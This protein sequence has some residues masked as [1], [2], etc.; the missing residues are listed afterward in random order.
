MSEP[1]QP[2]KPDQKQPQ[3]APVAIPHTH[4]AGAGGEGVHPPHPGQEVRG[5]YFYILTL[6]ALGVV[7]GDIGTSPLYA[8]R[9]CFFG[10]HGIEATSANIL[11]V[12]SLITWSL[13]L[14]ISVKYLVFVMRADNRGEGGILALMSLLRTTGRVG[15]SRP[16]LIAL[17]LFGAALLYGDGIITP[18][19]SVLGAIEGVEVAFP[20]VGGW[21]VPITVVIIIGLFLF[22]KRGTGGIGA[23]FGP[24]TL[25]WFLVIATL[26]AIQIVREPSVLAAVLPTHAVSFFVRNGFHG[27]IVLGSVFLVVTGGEALYADMG[28]FGKKPIKFA[29]FSVVL[30]ALLINYF[31]QGALM[32]NDPAAAAEHVFFRLA[33]GWFTIPLV[34]LAT[35]AA[36]IA[37]QAVISGAFSLTR[38]A[39][40][41]GYSPRVEIDH[42]SAREIGQIY[43]PAINWALMISTLVLVLAFRSA[44]AL[45]AAYGIAVTTT[46]V[47]TTLVFFMVAR[48]RFGWKLAA[49]AALAGFFLIIDLAFLGANA[50]KFLDG[51]Y[52]PIAIAAAIY[53]AMSAWKDGRRILAERLRDKTMPIDLFLSDVSRRPQNRVGGTAV[54]MTGSS[55]GIPPALLHNLKH[56]K[57]IHEQ[58]ILLTVVTKEVPHV[59][60]D[61]RLEVKHLKEGFYRVIVHYGFMED[62]NVPEIMNLVRGAGIMVRPMETTF[63]LGRDTLI[64]TKRAGMA[65]WRKRLFEVMSR[66]ARSATAFFGIPYNQVVELGTQIEF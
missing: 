29:W 33:P 60:R 42:T 25:L 37:S 66:N 28:H 59:G 50:V 17:G 52:V 51:G 57:V 5:K 1:G 8:L 21:V 15:R 11:G 30:P 32:F 9:E 43:I 20:N 23:V 19:I 63:F 46:M 58:V 24:V 44:S 62:P 36:S 56:N 45:A 13:I 65:R 7:Y 35:A 54:F 49:A 6:G 64:V 10:P 55:E 16:I 61:E 26:G 48:E 31:G 2:G 27:F 34:L 39:V 40:Q 38:Q 53:I 4:G 22:Q 3:R 41:L 47:I 18:A 12:L 14:V